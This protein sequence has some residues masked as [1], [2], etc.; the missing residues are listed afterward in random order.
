MANV[1]IVSVG[2][3]WSFAQ[4]L[5]DRLRSDRFGQWGTLDFN[6]LRR[7]C[8]RIQ[9]EAETFYD[10]EL[11][12]E[13]CND[14]QGHMEVEDQQAEEIKTLSERVEYLESCGM[15]GVRL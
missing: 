15:A 6:F 10:T 9:E 13:L 5:E 3:H 2:T 8:E 11:V 7:L 1:N 4:W 14:I 12:R